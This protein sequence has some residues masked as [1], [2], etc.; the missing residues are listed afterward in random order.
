MLLYIYLQE[1]ILKSKQT[2]LCI[3]PKWAKNHPKQL[4]VRKGPVSLSVSNPHLFFSDE[5]N[6]VALRP[7]TENSRTHVRLN[8][9]N[10][11]GF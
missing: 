3:N 2:E 7:N 6:I 1:F 10:S 4:E 11:K 9:R 8:P 5:L